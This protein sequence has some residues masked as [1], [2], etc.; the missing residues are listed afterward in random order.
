MAEA[1]TYTQPIPLLLTNIILYVFPNLK[2][3]VNLRYPDILWLILTPRFNLR[4]LNM[5]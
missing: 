3:G 5:V 1:H 4:P 2:F